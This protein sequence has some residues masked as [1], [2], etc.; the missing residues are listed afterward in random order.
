MSSNSIFYAVGRLSVIEKQRLNDQKL[1]RLFQAP[2]A[3]EARRILSEYDWPQTGN[4]EENASEHV[5]RACTL[6]KELSTDDRL[7]SAFLVRYDV[8]NLKILLK[9]RCLKKEAEHLS[10]CGTLSCDQ[11]R[12]AVA[13][14]QYH[15]LPPFVQ[16]ALNTLE[17]ELALSVN[18][19][20]IDVVLDK[21]H[22]AWVFSLLHKKHTTALAYFKARVDTL[23]YAFLLRAMHE[24]RNWTY[25]SPYLLEGG[26]IPLKTWERSFEKPEKLPMPMHRFGP[27]LYAAAIAAFMDREKQAQYEKEADN[28][29]LGY[30]KPYRRAL[31]KDER[32]IGHYLMRER[33]AAA[34]RLIL[35]GKENH[36]PKEAIQ[37]RLR[38]LY[39]A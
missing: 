34:V 24:G 15:G 25:V 29:L 2:D 27:K 30:F 39:G 9:S 4:D 23:N 37:E 22:Y 38:D 35:A 20:L 19:L 11:L 36:F 6:V 7:L 5:R 1:E 17:K 26:T 14:R 10:L 3:E 32:L 31:D 13:E 16:A 28:L 21:A 12:H 18:P 33:E 8:S